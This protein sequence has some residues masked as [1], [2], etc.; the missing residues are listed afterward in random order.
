MIL[1]D[2]AYVATH[3]QEDQHHW[4]FLGRRAVLRRVLRATL[5]AGGLRLVEIGCGGGTLLP[6]A[7]EFGEVVGVEASADFLEVARRRGFN[8]LRGALPDQLPLDAGAFDG[9]LLLDVLEHIEDD[10]GALEAVARV[11][12]PGGLLVCTVPAYPWLWSSHDEVLGH[13]RRYTAR[14]L[15]RVA[16]EAGFRPLRVTYFNTLLAPAV[17]GLRLL[18]RW[19]GVR[20]HDLVRPARPLNALLARVF[21]LE[22]SLLRWTDLPFGVS[23]LMVARR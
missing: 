17:V 11:L 13:R 15:R 10:R 5:P 2:P 9:A 20:S 22:A 14:S 16:Q 21:S 7:A 12:R 23:V 1:M 18:R 3:V 8:V 4:W 6:A 19:R